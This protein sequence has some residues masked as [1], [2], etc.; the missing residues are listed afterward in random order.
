M[1]L[2]L[3]FFGIAIAIADANENTN[4]IKYLLEFYWHDI[5]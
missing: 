2:M 3:N 5:A 4:T 1:Y